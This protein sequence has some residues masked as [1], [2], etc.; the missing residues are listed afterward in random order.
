MTP[1]EDQ[2]PAAFAEPAT[3]TERQVAEIWRQVLAVPRVGLHDNFFAL[4]GDSVLATKVLV[5]LRERMAVAIPMFQL[6]QSPSL[7]DFA[8]VVEAAPR[9]DTEQHAPIPVVPRGGLLPLSPAQQRM[10]FLSRFEGSSSAYCIPMALRLRGPI[11]AEALRRSLECIVARHE[12]LRTRF[13]AIDGIPFQQILAPSP[14]RLPIERDMG[15]PEDQRQARAEQ[16]AFRETHRPWDLATD[17]PFRARLIRFDPEDHLL[18]LMTHHIASDGWSK[19]VLFR[20]LEV[21]YAAELKGSEPELPPL[22]IQYA[23]YAQW[24]L[25]SLDGQSGGRFASYWAKRLEGLPALLDL[26]LDLPRPARQTFD[27]SILRAELPAS[28]RDALTE[29]S[30]KES[31]TLHMTLLAGLAALLYRYSGQEEFCVGVPTAARIRTEFEPLIGSFVNTLPIRAGVSGDLRFKDLLAQIRQSG[32][33][34]QACEEFPLERILEAVRPQRSLSYSPL[35][36]VLFQLRN[37][38]E[39]VTRLEGLQVEAVRFDSGTSQFDLS[40]DATGTSAGL[41]LT[42]IYN[43]ALFDR[44]TAERL[45]AHYQ[46]LLEAV[47]KDFETQVAKL[48]VLSGRERAQLLSDWNLTSAEY[49]RESALAL[50]EQQAARCPAN[51]AV[52]GGGRTLSYRELDRQADAI[53]SHLGRMGVKR[54]SLVAICVERSPAMLAALLG[55]WKAGAAYVPLDP[56]YPS[57]RLQFIL[58]DSGAHALL[59]ERALEGLFP[60]LEIPVLRLDASHQRLG[61]ERGESAPGAEDLA[62]VIYTSGST[63]KPKGVP[64]RHRSLVNL[65]ASMS[66]TLEFTATERVLALT[67]ISFDISCLELFLPLTVGAEVLVGSRDLSGDGAKLS[68]AIERTQATLVQ[69]TPATWQILT[70]GGWT[71]RPGLKIL[72]GGEPLPKSLAAKL[73]RNASLWN[74]Y[75][76]TETAIW[77]T[78]ARIQTDDDRITIGRPIDNTQVYVLDSAVQPVPV[79]VAGELYLGGDGLAPGYW[80]RPELTAERFV[81]NPFSADP[82]SRLYRTGDLVRYLPDGRIEFL[83]RA[84]NQVKLRG[85]RIELEEVEFAAET[86]AGIGSAAAA[87]LKAGTPEARLALFYVASAEVAPSIGDLRRHLKESL[88]GYM[89]PSL[90][91]PVEALPQ[92]PAG[93]TDRKALAVLA[94]ESSICSGHAATSTAVSESERSMPEELLIEIWEEALGRCPIQR[95]DDFFALGGHS[96]L[97]ARLLARVENAFG[98]SLP[99]S[100]FFEAP[101]VAQML[102]CLGPSAKAAHSKV[103]PIRSSGSGTPL[104]VLHPSPFFRSLYLALPEQARVSAVSVPAPPPAGQQLILEQMAERQLG[105]IRKTQPAGPLALLGWCADGVL[106]LEMAQQ[107]RRLGGGAPLVV[108]LDTFAPRKWRRV[109]G[110]ETAWNRV[111]RHVARGLYHAENLWR[112]GPAESGNY[113]KRRWNSSSSRRGEGDGSNPALVKAA[114]E[115]EPSPYAGPVVLFRA[116]ERPRGAS[117]DSVSFWGEILQD[118]D[119]VDVPGNHIEMLREPN[120][121]IIARHLSRRLGWNTSSGADLRQLAAALDQ[122]AFVSMEAVAEPA[123]VE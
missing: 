118:L 28:L 69:A 31:A 104:Y 72:S 85:F 71:T 18:I 39:I 105:A 112:L 100:A 51:P 20:E 98:V 26:P 14:F 17:S 25:G 15:T 52:S 13:A 53:A 30:R 67:T 123:G 22:P 95:E 92:T 64:I 99:L 45:L 113:L 66:K 109:T 88:P 3:D 65:L 1:V 90:F 35:F 60:R 106:A 122:D 110:R 70:D 11:E 63:G 79:G 86:H 96:L 7:G 62:Y 33:E 21:C 12:I 42:L 81:P 82:A 83:R 76:P 9:I 38:P 73:C 91:V 48:P 58:E 115:Y 29:A 77:S 84:D 93:K 111:G 55:I 10:W 34:A 19:S 97:G 5:R 40:L 75:G 94:E 68:A 24:Q 36:Q 120:V 108:L 32:L 87:I 59:I 116:M 107:I 114:W 6:F 46:I 2:A 80:R 23:D 74:C 47:A 119:V 61:V 89:V 101:T 103:I 16:L 121:Q 27:G 43:T 44:A 57:Q 50:F 117:A 78:V 37:F 49:P 56:S 41:E 8:R 102:A 54:G 4:G